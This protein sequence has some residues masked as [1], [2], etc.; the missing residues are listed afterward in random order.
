MV[1][2]NFA[3]FAAHRNE[4]M[5]VRAYLEALERER[6]QPDGG[7]HQGSPERRLPVS[8][9]HQAGGYWTGRSRR[10]GH[11]PGAI[12]TDV[13][14]TVLEEKF[15][16]VA[17]SYGNRRGI[18]YAAWRVVGVDPAVLRKAGITASM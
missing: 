6:L 12:V 2:E 14:L 16:A 9:A 10:N 3:V 11:G 8:D 15:V 4:T 13:D 18:C 1:D 17:S 5:A 7:G